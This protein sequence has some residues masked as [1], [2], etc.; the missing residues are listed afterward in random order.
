MFLFYPKGPF[1]TLLVALSA[2]L[3]HV[4]AHFKVELSATVRR[5][6]LR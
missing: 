1:G 3:Q 2:V 4:I 5:L 6:E